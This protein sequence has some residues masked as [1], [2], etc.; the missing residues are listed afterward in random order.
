MGNG[1]HE[2]LANE[3]SL[4]RV[5]GSFNIP[6][7]ALLHV[8]SFGIIPKKGQRD[9]WRLTVDLSSVGRWGGACVNDGI[10]IPMNSL[11]I[12]SRLTKLFAWFRNLVKEL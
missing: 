7:L 12:I 4:G 11:C 1:T 9:K 10:S 3:E 5:A 6:P 2:Y 8:N